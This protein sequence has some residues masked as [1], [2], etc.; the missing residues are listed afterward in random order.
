MPGRGLMMRKKSATCICIC[1]MAAAHAV[2]GDLKPV[3]C[4]LEQGVFPPLLVQGMIS[5]K[6]AR[7]VADNMVALR[8]AIL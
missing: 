8:K 3:P 4:D 1:L 5:A 6:P 2:G 7:S